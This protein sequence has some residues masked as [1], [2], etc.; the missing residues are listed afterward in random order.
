MYFLVPSLRSILKNLS[1][2]ACEASCY[3]FQRSF[4]SF[5]MTI[6]GMTVSVMLSLRSIL[7]TRSFTSFRMTACF[8]DDG[9]CS[10]CPSCWACE[11]SCCV[12]QRSFTSFRMTVCVQDDGMCSMCPS[13]WACEAS[14]YVFWETF[15]RSFTAFRMTIFGMISFIIIFLDK[16]HL[17]FYYFVQSD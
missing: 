16:D 15:E 10:M 12:F 5:R 6:I 17:D 14:C 9:M 3:V 2:W 7:L 11:A 13:C 4:T 8:Q 1:C